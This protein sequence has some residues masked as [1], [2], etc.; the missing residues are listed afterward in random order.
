MP[1]VK[2]MFI[3]LITAQNILY[4]N[5]STK[6]IHRCASMTTNND[7]TLLIATRV[8]TKH[9]AHCYVSMAK[10]LTQMRYN[11]TFYVHCLSYFLL[12][13]VIHTAT[14]KI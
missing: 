13:L 10:V 9:G 5:N 1:N 7:F 6:L 14:S 4:L 12:N 8:S 3:L 11:F 2:S